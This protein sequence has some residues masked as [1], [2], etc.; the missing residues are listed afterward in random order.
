M[1]QMVLG[2][3]SSTYNSERAVRWLVAS[4]QNKAPTMRSSLTSSSRVNR[5]SRGEAAT[6]IGAEQT[7]PRRGRTSRVFMRT[8]DRWPNSFYRRTALG[9]LAYPEER[10]REDRREIDACSA[11]VSRSCHYKSRLRTAFLYRMPLCCRIHWAIID[12]N[13][14]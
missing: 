7:P 2:T 3:V 8:R 1:A 13:S 4:A 6:S 9:A 12:I 14:I 10:V 11:A 5:A